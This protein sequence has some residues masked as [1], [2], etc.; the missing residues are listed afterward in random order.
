MKKIVMIGTGGLAREFCSYFSDYDELISIVG[1]SS[2]NF[3]EHRLFLLSGKLFEGDITPKTVGTDEIVI[4][5]GT[6]SVKKRISEHFKRLGFCFSSLIHPRSVVSDR[7]TLGEGVIVSPNC[8]VS[9]N[10]HLKD[11]CYLNFRVVVGHEA[12]LGNFCQ[13]NPVFNLPAFQI[14][15]MKL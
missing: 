8:T 11:F 1:F 12:V 10:V 13:V 4:A 9:P 5:I 6:P 14:L 2:T 3:D 15:V 7:A